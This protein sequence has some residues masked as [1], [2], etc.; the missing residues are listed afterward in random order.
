MKL[1]KILTFLIILLIVFTP[2]ILGGISTTGSVDSEWYESNKPG[3]T[4]PNWIFGPAWTIL[5]ILIAFSLFSAWIKST[6]TDKKNLSLV[7]GINLLSNGIWSYFFFVLQMPLLAFLDLILIW[8]SILAMILITYKI[9]KKSA[10]LLI[11]YLL[12]VT[13]AGILNLGFIF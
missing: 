5:Y 11:P 6:K 2:A 3:F 1:N 12:W 4:P 13:F 7:F 10:Y 9:D 8:I